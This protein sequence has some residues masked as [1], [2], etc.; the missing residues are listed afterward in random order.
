MSAAYS[1]NPAAGAG[2]MPQHLRR[3]PAPCAG[4][5]NDAPGPEPPLVPRAANDWSQTILG[6]HNG[7]AIG[8]ALSTCVEG[9]ANTRR[10]L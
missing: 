5:S 6:I 9:L 7:F 8:L 1:V 4:A 2:T 10:D 3:P